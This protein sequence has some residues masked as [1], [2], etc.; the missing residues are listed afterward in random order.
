MLQAIKRLPKEQMRQVWET[1]KSKPKD[2]ATIDATIKILEDCGA[3]E[4]CVTQSVDMVVRG[5]YCDP[6][7]L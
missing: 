4:E 2:R 6:A 3:I 1:I 5:L 7:S